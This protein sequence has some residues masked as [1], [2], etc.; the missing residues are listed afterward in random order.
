MLTQGFMSVSRRKGFERRDTWIQENARLRQNIADANE[1]RP[2]DLS[3]NEIS[4]ILAFL[5]A[6]TDPSVD[7]LNELVPERVPSGLPVTD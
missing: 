6:L 7:H 2:V 1:L 3:S 4:K 5:D